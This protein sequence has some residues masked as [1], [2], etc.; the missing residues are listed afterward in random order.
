MYQIT[1]V[2]FIIGSTISC[3]SKPEGES[4][5]SQSIDPANPQN[6]LE[7]LCSTY[8]PEEQERKKC[9]DAIAK[10]PWMDRFTENFLKF[11]LRA[12]LDQ[13][14]SNNEYNKFE[15]QESAEKCRIESCGELGGLPKCILARKQPNSEP[16][17]W[18]LDRTGFRKCGETDYF[19]ATT[20]KPSS[21]V[22]Q[23]FDAAIPICK[24]LANKVTLAAEID[25]EYTD[26][27]LN[28]IIAGGGEEFFRE[29]GIENLKVFAINHK[30]ECNQVKPCS[31]FR[32]R[33]CFQ[34]EDQSTQKS[35]WIID[36][37]QNKF[38]R[39][40]PDL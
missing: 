33:F 31:N 9:K 18:I 30:S 10:T 4:S 20:P 28:R 24:Q 37:N 32:V 3:N 35:F 19:V 21:T 40:Q 13:I 7:V 23:Q 26:F 25:Q 34:A 1:I 15:L 6:N 38:V 12:G 36:G 16:D 8:Y 2:L 22:C 11:A 14:I 17:L 39:C 29:N 5:A 27:I